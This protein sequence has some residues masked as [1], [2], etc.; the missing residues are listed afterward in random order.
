MNFYSIHLDAF[1]ELSYVPVLYRK[2]MLLIF[3]SRS[4]VLNFIYRYSYFPWKLFFY[5][6]F[7]VWGSNPPKILIFPSVI[8]IV[9]SKV[10]SI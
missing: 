1:A 7:N 8:Q 3:E 2:K 9:L 4:Y 6:F 10:F 5:I